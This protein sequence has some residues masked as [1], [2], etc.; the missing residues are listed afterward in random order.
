LE[1]N[2]C[3]DEV[4]DADFALACPSLR[5]FN[6]E[7][8][9]VNR[10][11]NLRAKICDIQEVLRDARYHSQRAKALRAVIEICQN[12]KRKDVTTQGSIRG[13]TG[14][15]ISLHYFNV[16]PYNL[17]YHWQLIS[18]V[19]ALEEDKQ[20]Q[21]KAQPNLLSGVTNGRLFASSSSWERL[22]TAV[23]PMHDVSNSEQE[24]E[25]ALRAQF[26]FCA[27]EIGQILNGV[28]RFLAVQELKG[29]TYKKRKI[30]LSVQ[31]LYQRWKAL[32]FVKVQRH[33]QVGRFQVMKENVRMDHEAGREAYRPSNCEHG[34][35]SQRLALASTKQGNTP[36]PG[37]ANRTRNSTP[38]PSCK[39]HGKDTQALPSSTCG[40]KAQKNEEA[41]RNKSP[42]T[43][44]TIKEIMEEWGFTNPAMARSLL[45]RRQ[46]LG[47][48]CASTTTKKK[49]HG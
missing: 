2:P 4:P 12:G 29:V 6:N 37:P 33:L 46:K 19:L 7:N 8:L 40:L 20:Y 38:S 48:G 21:R 35:Q 10:N 3:T 15:P 31:A 43:S 26:D 27:Q 23:G 18:R 9:V 17:H 13:G 32:S 11:Q 34:R 14:W 36:R 28:R 25:T 44:K 39:E 24:T 42:G 1:D 5:T 22:A 30:A 16:N 45:R 41:K 47:K 49:C